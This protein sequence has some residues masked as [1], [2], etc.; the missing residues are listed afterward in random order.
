MF[1][2]VVQDVFSLMALQLFLVQAFRT[3]VTEVCMN[4]TEPEEPTITGSRRNQ[5]SRLLLGEYA[6]VGRSIWRIDRDTGGRPVS[7][8]MSVTL[9]APSYT[10]L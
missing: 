8:W 5:K 2:K 3:A 4:L 9:E 1:V 7:K 6:E 10:A